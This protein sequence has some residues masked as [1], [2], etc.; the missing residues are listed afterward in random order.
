MIWLRAHHNTKDYSSDYKF[1]FLKKYT[2]LQSGYEK[3][4]IYTMQPHILRLV[5]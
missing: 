5:N 2:Q 1:S 3:K 4:E